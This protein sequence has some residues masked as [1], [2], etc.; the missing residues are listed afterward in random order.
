MWV[1]DGQSPGFP[2]L[3]VCPRVDGNRKLALSGPTRG[4][5]LLLLSEE[6]GLPLLLKD[7]RLRGS[8]VMSV[9]VPTRQSKQR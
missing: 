3:P 2:A 9:L 8:E 4:L 1:E 6:L 7:E 5:M